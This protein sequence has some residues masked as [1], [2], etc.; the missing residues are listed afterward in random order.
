MQDPS[1]PDC[2]TQKFMSL[3]KESFYILLAIG[4]NIDIK[5][6]ETIVRSLVLVNDQQ[7]NI[8]TVLGLPASYGPEDYNCPDVRFLT[9]RLKEALNPLLGRH[10]GPFVNC[11][12]HVRCVLARIMHQL[13]RMIRWTRL[14][15]LKIR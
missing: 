1:E 10:T 14:T 15:R 6:W 8:E 4:P 7:I 11:P 5:G 3:P 13:T 12:E 9:P 2:P